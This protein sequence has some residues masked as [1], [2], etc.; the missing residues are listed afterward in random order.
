[1]APAHATLPDRHRLLLGLNLGGRRVAMM[2]LLISSSSATRPSR[3]LPVPALRIAGIVANLSGGL[4]G[5]ALRHPVHAGVG[6]GV[7]DRGLAMLSAIDPGWPDAASVPGWS[8]RRA[9]R[10]GKDFTKNAFEIGIKATR[11]RAA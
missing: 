6:Q 3:S 8:W 11:A 1:M 9:R 7:A 10:A 2:V 4:A 5:N